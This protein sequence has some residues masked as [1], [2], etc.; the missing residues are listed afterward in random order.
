[1]KKRL[2]EE[3]VIFISI[4]KWL[5][6]ASIIG[7]IVGLS[8]TLFLK[9][10]K[11]STEFT[12]QNNWYFLLLPVALFI[13]AL[14]IKHLAPDAEG[15]GARVIESVHK[16]SG[17]IPWAVVPIK[18]ITTIL[19][20]AFG[21]SV[22]KEGPC[23]Q[24]GAG[25]SSLFAKVFRFSE[26]DRKKLVICGIS[27]G[28]AA[29]FGTPIAGA[30]FGI[31]V[32]F[33]G[34]ILYE[35]L[36]PSFVAGIISY[37]VSSTLGVAYF[38]YPLE[39]VPVFS[40]AFFIKVVIAGIFF[41]I[42]SFL[43]IE[44][45]HL[46]LKLRRNIINKYGIFGIN[47]VGLSLIGGIALIILALVFSTKFLGLG[48][49]TLRLTLEGGDVPAYTFFVKMVF[50]SITLNFGG[51]GGIVTPVLFVGATAG[52]FIAKVMGVEPATFAA[53]GFVSLLAGAANTPIA[54]SILA[55]ELFGAEIAPYAAVA[56]VISFIMT[57]HRSVYPSQ[58]LA[59]KKSSSIKVDIGKEM[60]TIRPM[61]EQRDKSLISTTRNFLE[62]LMEIGHTKAEGPGGPDVGGGG[63]G[64]PPG[65]ESAKGEGA[66]G[67]GGSGDGESAGGEPGKGG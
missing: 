24:I 18:F 28:F 64:G 30:I 42:C 17:K 46:G 8:T 22:G 47:D 41:G 11:Y 43:L 26:S 14:M 44:S 59:M 67:P 33:V 27:G 52:N 53:I 13:S 51:S 39:F 57:G 21:G 62:V 54:A 6:L 23:A 65:D 61:Y 3:T 9:T 4:V 37:Q 19:T 15:Y 5:V 49:E 48:L 29:V 34:G 36:L 45:L 16:T 2:K 40:E 60:E 63:G 7:G 12:A 38:Y 66:G 25:L 55:V 20:L 32:L 1:M 50:T 35:V 56:S 31:E 10:L 58:I